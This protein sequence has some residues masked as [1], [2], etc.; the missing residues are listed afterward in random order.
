VNKILVGNK[1]D[2]DESKRVW[3]LSI[4]YSYLIFQLSCLELTLISYMPI[5]F[6]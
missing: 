5:F 1:A 2:M 4:L 3:N 6:I